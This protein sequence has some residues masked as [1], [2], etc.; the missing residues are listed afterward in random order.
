MGDSAQSNTSICQVI[1]NGPGQW[2]SQ[3][4][5]FA[6]R[7]RDS[8]FWLMIENRAILIKTQFLDC[9]TASCFKS[10]AENLKLMATVNI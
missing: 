6:C 5:Q 9:C 1:K 3:A 10:S 4:I 8:K 2:T 7:D